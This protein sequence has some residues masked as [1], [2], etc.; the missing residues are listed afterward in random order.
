MM[1]PEGYLEFLP[2]NCVINWLHSK[3][4]VP[5]CPGWSAKLLHGKSG[6]G[7]IGTCPYN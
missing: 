3:E 1:S 5:P 7:G 6:L 4:M 2:S